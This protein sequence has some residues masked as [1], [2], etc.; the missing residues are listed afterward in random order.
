[1]VDLKGIKGA[2][3]SVESHHTITMTAEALAEFFGAP[4]DAVIE[5]EDTELDTCAVYGTEMVSVRWS[6]HKTLE[7]GDGA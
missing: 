7:G 4:K 1:M 6:E 2:R 5:I 3:Y